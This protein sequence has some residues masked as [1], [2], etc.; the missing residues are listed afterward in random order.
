MTTGKRTKQNIIRC[1]DT[2]ISDDE[3]L[4]LI[5]QKKSNNEFVGYVKGDMYFKIIQVRCLKTYKEF[6]GAPPSRK[7]K[8]RVT[9]DYKGNI[10]MYKVGK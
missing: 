1:P 6:D 10:F 4:K 5:A 2:L 7:H 9:F 3:I 8:M